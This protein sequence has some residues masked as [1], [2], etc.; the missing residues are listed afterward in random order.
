LILGQAQRAGSGRAQTVV[1]AVRRLLRCLIAVGHCAPGLAHAIPTIAR[2]RR[3]SLP[4]YFSAEAVERV[5]ASCDLTTPRGRR[6]RAVLLL[7][8]RLA[9]RAGDVPALQFRH[10]DGDGSTVQVAEKSRRPHRLPLPH[11]V[12]DALLRYLDDRPTVPTDQVFLTTRAPF[13]RLRYQAVGQMATPAMARAGTETPIHGSHVLRH[14][15]ATPMRRDGL[16]LSALGVV[17]RHASLA[18]TAG[19]ATGDVPLLQ[20][21]VQPWPEVTS[22]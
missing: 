10:L 15:A 14:A 12:G 7:L 9:R 17:L 5:I 13:K 1:T 6:D 19:D 16:P 22:W 11:E 21:V 18:T 3:A 4:T 2:G 20:A 8:A